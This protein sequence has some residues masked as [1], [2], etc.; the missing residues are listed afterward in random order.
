MKNG[1]DERQKYTLFA[2]ATSDY[3]RN[4]FILRLGSMASG[5]YSKHPYV[6]HNN[7]K[8]LINIYVRVGER[9]TM[10]R[11][12]ENTV[13]VELKS[14]IHEELCDI[15]EDVCDSAIV[16]RN[17]REE[18]L[19]D[20]MLLKKYVEHESPDIRI[21]YSSQTP[22]IV[23]E[24]ASSVAGPFMVDLEKEFDRILPSLNITDT[25]HN[26][27]SFLEM[28]TGLKVIWYEHVVEQNVDYK[29]IMELQAVLRKAKQAALYGW[30]IN[31][32]TG[33]MTHLHIYYFRGEV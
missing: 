6:N 7:N 17:R 25:T 30:S 14:Y 16:I 31:R 23:D 32:Y 29:V 8:P 3:I 9:V 12:P 19:S 11:V 4:I 21:G 26:L 24:P 27:Q 5:T 22:F 13:V 28:P 33:F 20:L 1:Q 15:F 10:L 18:P 2:L